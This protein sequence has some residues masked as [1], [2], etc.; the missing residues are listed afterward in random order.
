MTKEQMDSKEYACNS[1]QNS[2]KHRRETIFI[3]QLSSDN[4][5]IVLHNY[6]IKTPHT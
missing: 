6:K 1:V 4:N 5:I 2:L 3:S